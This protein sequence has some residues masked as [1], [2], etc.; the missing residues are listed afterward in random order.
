MDVKDKVY[1]GILFMV[2]RDSFG[3]KIGVRMTTMKQFEIV[4]PNL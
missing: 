4:S 2:K 1:K 3:V